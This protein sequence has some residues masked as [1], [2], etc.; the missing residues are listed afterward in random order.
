MRQ[1]GGLINEFMLM[2]ST[3]NMADHWPQRD[4]VIQWRRVSIELLQCMHW[5]SERTK[6]MSCNEVIAGDIPKD[7]FLFCSRDESLWVGDW[8]VSVIHVQFPV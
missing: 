8:I 2:A 1:Q 6:G 4:W 3:C 7:L 5:G